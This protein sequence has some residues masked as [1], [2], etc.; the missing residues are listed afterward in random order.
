MAMEIG[1]LTMRNPLDEG[2]ID[3]AR[4]EEAYSL[5]RRDMGRR[6]KGAGKGGGK[7]GGK[8]SPFSGRCFNC[9]ETGHRAAECPKLSDEER[10]RRAA[11]GKGKGVHAVEEDGS[12]ILPSTGEDS[13]WDFI[14]AAY[15]LV[16]DKTTSVKNR[17]AAL[18][19]EAGGQ[20]EQEELRPEVFPALPS[21]G[22]QT[23]PVKSRTPRLPK[24]PPRKH[25][26]CLGCGVG[27][28][29]AAEADLA[30]LLLETDGDQDIMPLRE[31][32]HRRP[33]YERYT[34]LEVA[35]DSGAA[36]SVMPERC[37][38]DHPVVPSEGSRNGVHY[39]SANGGRIPNQGEMQLDFITKERHRCH[40]AFQVA[41]VKRPLLAV[42]TLTRAGN[43]V[44]FNASG[45]TITNKKTGRSMSFVKRD[46][47]YILEIMVAPP[48]AGGGS[49][50]FARP[51]TAARASP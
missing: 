22:S 2:D 13:G 34:K 40:I 32:R 25:C 38:P 46:G 27:S 21:P 39:L 44:S 10:K 41:D 20:E 6:G 11:K 23:R 1:N 35:V 4:V 9:Q 26:R 24:M 3:P 29:P 42:S 7:T 15:S 45:G 18:T 43:D 14:L 50:G 33:E 16:V 17:F 8:G 19:M 5:V 49:R 48:T 36:A 31:G 37:L 47:I 12:G 51:G 30:P 28:Q